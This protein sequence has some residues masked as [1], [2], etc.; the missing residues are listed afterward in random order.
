MIKQGA[1]VQPIAAVLDF[2]IDI[3]KLASINPV[4]Q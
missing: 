2:R 4:I 1:I 3:E